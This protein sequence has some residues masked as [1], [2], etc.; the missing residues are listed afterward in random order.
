MSPSCGLNATFDKFL[1]ECAITEKNVDRQ[2][3]EFIFVRR[4]FPGKILRIFVKNVLQQLYGH[5]KAAEL[6][7]VEHMNLRAATDLAS[8]LVEGGLEIIFAEIHARKLEV[9]HVLA[10]LDGIDKL[11]LLE[12]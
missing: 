4:L 12:Y 6:V 2:L 11:I 7:A 3:L 10:K 5:I 8:P 1:A 9:V